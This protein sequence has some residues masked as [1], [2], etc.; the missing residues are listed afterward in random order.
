M[1]KNAV[2]SDEL[3]NK[4]K[5]EKE[6]PYTRWVKAEGL[7]IIPSFYVQNLNTVALKPW[8]AKM[9]TETR[10]AT[11]VA[12]TEPTFQTFVGAPGGGKVVKSRIVDRA[13]EDIPSLPALLSKLRVTKR[14]IG[15]G[16]GIV[17]GQIFG[18][19]GHAPIMDERPWSLR[20]RSRAS[21]RASSRSCDG[22]RTQGNGVE[23]LVDDGVNE[24]VDTLLAE[25][26]RPP[27]QPVDDLVLAVDITFRQQSR[28]LALL[29]GLDHCGAVLEHLEHSVVDGVDHRATPGDRVGHGRARHRAECQ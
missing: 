26:R 1:A 15:V 20:G 23:A 6:T 19:I 22:L 4:F 13:I 3:A 25:A 21:G 17:R 10:V 28:Q 2:V 9:M 7:D 27:G 14:R 29:H 24:A 16:G 11:T 12:A 18:M 5:T 8:V